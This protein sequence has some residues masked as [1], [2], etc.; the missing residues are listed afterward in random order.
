MRRQQ[1]IGA[2]VA[3]VGGAGLLGAC[4]PTPGKFSSAARRYIESKEVADFAQ[5]AAFTNA[6]CTDPAD[7][8]VKTT[9]QC[10]ATGSDGHTYVFQV[11]ITGDRKFRIESAQPND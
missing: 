2:A 10:T 11:V 7:V 9:F 4:S 3:V 6:S 8:K 1:V 5:Q